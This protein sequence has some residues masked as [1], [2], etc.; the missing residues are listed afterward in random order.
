ML[1][2]AQ[3]RDTISLAL[4][5]D[6]TRLNLSDSVVTLELWVALSRCGPGEGVVLWVLLFTGAQF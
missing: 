6:T 3:A 5:S 4:R 1:V 2:W